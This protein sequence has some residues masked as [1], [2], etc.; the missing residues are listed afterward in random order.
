MIRV[1]LLLVAS[2]TLAPLAFA[3]DE[4]SSGLEPAALQEDEVHGDDG[5]FPV[6]VPPPGIALLALGAM[7]V[8][9]VLAAPR[10]ER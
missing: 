4:N 7:G 1:A 10:Q 9:L 5:G 2:L 3:G 8:G 6:R